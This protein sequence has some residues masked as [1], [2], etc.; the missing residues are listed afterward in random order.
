MLLDRARD[1]SFFLGLGSAALHDVF[2]Q[3]PNIA[4]L[5]QEGIV[6]VVAVKLNVVADG[7]GILNAFG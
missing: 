5:G 3:R 6:S 4:D 2:N 1:R 7:V